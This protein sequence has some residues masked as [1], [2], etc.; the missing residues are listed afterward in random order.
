MDRLKTTHTLQ[1]LTTKLDGCSNA[2]K[3][4]PCTLFCFSKSLSHGLS[5]MK[6]L[7]ILSNTWLLLL[8]THAAYS[9]T[10]P[11][12]NFI[13]SSTSLFSSTDESLQCLKHFHEGSWRGQARSFTITPDLAAGVIQRKKTP[14]YKLSLEFDNKAGS[15]FETIEF[16]DDTGDQRTFG[17]IVP[18]AKSNLDIDSV[19][20]SYSMDSS[21]SDYCS[22]FSGTSQY[23]HFVVEHC[24][25]TSNQDRARCL[26][27]YGT[28]QQLLRV[29]VAEEHRLGEYKDPQNQPPSE[30]FTAQDFVE[31]GAEAEVAKRIAT[32]MK[33][34]NGPSPSKVI[35]AEIVQSEVQGE[36]ED[37]VTA[38]VTTKLPHPISLFDLSLGIWLGDVIIRSRESA[39]ALNSWSS[40][41]QKI[42]CRWMWNYE[43]EI[44]L[45]Q[46]QGKSIGHPVDDKMVQDLGGSVVLDESFS[47]TITDKMACIDWDEDNVGFLVDSY[48]IQL[49]RYVD[50]GSAKRRRHPFYTEFCAYQ[51][52]HAL[53]KDPV[54]PR[55]PMDVIS[56]AVKEDELPKL[57]CSKIQRLYDSKGGLKQACTAFLTFKRFGTDGVGSG[58][59]TLKEVESWA[60]NS[61]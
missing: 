2:V 37:I 50:F 61:Q 39:T 26:A 13:H 45:V 9:F 49:P 22:I 32:K 23:A 25:A 52:E 33:E 6:F 57:I 24:I 60:R 21:Q 30:P 38:N 51:A 8:C 7:P 20:A 5:N 42:A 3:G 35:D 19:D 58:D 29:V 16:N 27:F 11:H 44:R 1:K 59:T 17:R 48:S 53:G 54:E 12:E 28:D 55:N 34:N 46:Y 40:G 41:V 4:I 18:I 47:K 43:D 31:M 14:E 15:V 36:L 10:I 56:S